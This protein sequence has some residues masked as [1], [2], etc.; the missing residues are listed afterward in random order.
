MASA[1]FRITE[2]GRTD[3]QKPAAA[4][5]GGPGRAGI[6]SALYPIAALPLFALGGREL[7]TELLADGPGEEPADTVS[8]P[9]RGRHDLLQ[10]GPVRPL[11][12][13][14]HLLGFR[15]LTRAGFLLGALG[16][17]WLFGPL[18]GFACLLSRLGLA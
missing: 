18:L 11:Q 9:A 2:N 12:Q 15:A 3:A 14:Q 7:Q 10:C 4:W 1:H 8:L 5:P 16:G 6:A 13:V 17:L